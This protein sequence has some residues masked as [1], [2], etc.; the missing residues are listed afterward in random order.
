MTT[1]R[2][3][4]HAHSFHTARAHSFNNAAAQYA[5]NRPSYPPTL[6]DTIEALSPHPLHGSRTVDVGAGTGISTTLLHTRGAHV[7]AVEPGAGMAA[8]FRRTH[9]HLPLVR[10]DGN[11]LPI[12]T[13]ST[14]FL[15]YAQSWH[16]TDPSRSVPEALRVLRPGGVLALWWNTDAV[17]IPWIADATTR[18]H[19]FLGV[20]HDTPIE[21]S[22]SGAPAALADTAGHLDFTRRPIRW[23]RTVSLDTHLANIASHSGFLVLGEDATAE[24]LTEERAHLRR[25]FPT[26][27]IEETYDV[28]LLV[29][30]RP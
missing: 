6:F 9:P 5:A 10:G 28:D 17:D 11:A 1:S 7:L 14:D 2:P 29:A 16:W 30:I 13:A 21:K 23:S 22:G 12:A 26:E 15:T 27:T 19:R 20:D 8:Q 25:L 24:F 4:P 18:I 3:H